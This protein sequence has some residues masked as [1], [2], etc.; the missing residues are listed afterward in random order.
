MKRFLGI[1]NS[2][3]LSVRKTN[4]S[5]SEQGNTLS[6]HPNKG[7]LYELKYRLL[8]FPLVVS[9]FLPVFAQHEIETRET[10][11]LTVV[12]LTMPPDKYSV[13]GAMLGGL[14]EV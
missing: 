5:W 8:L 6:R 13:L 1:L 14:L 11:K 2:Q 3:F 12:L 4:S 7:I 9:G 10:E